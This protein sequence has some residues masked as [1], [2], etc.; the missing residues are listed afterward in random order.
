M[1][2]DLGASSAPPA[3]VW[4]GGDEFD[5]AYPGLKG[6]AASMPNLDRRFKR[7]GSEAGT[8]RPITTRSG[9]GKFDP[10]ADASGSERALS[11]QNRSR[12]RVGP[13]RH[14]PS[15]LY[16]SPRRSARPDG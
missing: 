14:D 11:T 12:Q 5:N 2:D 6:R 8:P 7:D 16:C 10:L 4:P 3:G 9:R 13:P 15:S 1:V